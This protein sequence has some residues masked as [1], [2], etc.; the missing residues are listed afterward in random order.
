MVVQAKNW[1]IGTFQFRNE[2]VLPGNEVSHFI[3]ELA[4]IQVRQ[5]TGEILLAVSET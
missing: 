5:Y 2:G 1:Y 3:I 4:L